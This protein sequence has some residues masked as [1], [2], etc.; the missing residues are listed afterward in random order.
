MID[1]EFNKDTGIFSIYYQGEEPISY[2]FWVRDLSTNLVC[3]GWFTGFSGKGISNWQAPLE[4][5]NASYISGFEVNG[6][7]N[8]E[9]VFTKQFQYK[10]I[11]NNL[12]LYVLSMN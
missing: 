11:D 8:N 5:T 2:Q 6:V 4:L 1:I 7:L 12:N 9:L 10:K 3:F